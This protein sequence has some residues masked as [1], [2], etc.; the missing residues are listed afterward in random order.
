MTSA[1]DSVKSDETMAFFRLPMVLCHYTPC[2]AY[3]QG[4]IYKIYFGD[5]SQ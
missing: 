4:V 3:L 1:W 2:G 5:P